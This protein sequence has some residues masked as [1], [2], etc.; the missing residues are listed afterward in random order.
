MFQP[1]HISK[2]RLKTLSMSCQCIHIFNSD[3]LIQLPITVIIIYCIY[4]YHPSFLET[5]VGAEMETARATTDF[6]FFM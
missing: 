6:V 1:L 2:A 3:F 4:I 5:A